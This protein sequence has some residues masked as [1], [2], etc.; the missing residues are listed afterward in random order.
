MLYDAS[1]FVGTQEGRLPGIIEGTAPFI[2]AGIELLIPVLLV[3]SRTRFAGIVVLVVFHLVIS[4][5]PSSTA[6]DFTIMLVAIAYL[7]LPEES[8][9]HVI[10]RFRQIR[11]YVPRMLGTDMRSIPVVLLFFL[12]MAF[13]SRLGTIA[14]NRGW[15]L[16]AP[17]SLVIGSLLVFLVARS[18]SSQP[19]GSISLSGIKP[20]HYALIG[21]LLFNVA[22]PYMGI[23]TVGTFTMY[24]NLNTYGLRITWHELR[25]ELARDPKASISYIRGGNCS[26]MREPI[27]IL[28]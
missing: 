3:V 28:D 26:S 2:V 12:S 24:S 27:R 22:S 11:S 6:I 4:I 21:L 15:A 8:S 20:P 1:A 17:V 9:E 25:R 5:S 13:L 14:G 7:L 23:K 10:L 16:L 19:R 18:R